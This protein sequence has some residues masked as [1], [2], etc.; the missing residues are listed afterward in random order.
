MVDAAVLEKLE[1]GFAKIAASDS[2]SLLKKYLTK[3]VFDSLKNK[4]TPSFGSTLLDVVQSGFE[5]HDSGVGIY[6]P[7]A[8]AYTTFAELFDPI[9]EDYH[10]G[11][12]KTDKH[13]AKDFG[14]VNAFGDLDPTGE[15]VVST[16]V[17]CGRS[18]EGYPFN[19]CLTEAQYKE[20]EQ[21][22][23][24]TLSGLEGELKGKF[25]PLT[26]MDK[27]TQQQLID[28]H[29]LFK[30]GDRF[31]QAANACRF[32]P[33]GRGI[34]HNDAKTF[35]V[36]CNEED[37]LRIISM[38]MGGNLGEVFRRLTTAVNDIEKRVPF[39]HNDRLGFLT[40][41]PTNLG[42]TIRA[43]VHI[44]VPKLA[45]NKARL[46]EVAAKYNLQVRGTR[47]EHT[48]AEGGIYDISNK[49]R[50]GLTEFQAVKEMY[51]G[52]TEIIK[53]EKSL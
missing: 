8:E 1:A 40:F 42:T 28:D 27:A 6:A 31:L 19:P 46:E 7:D 12:K 39:S 15:F 48:E 35:L 21:K 49:R 50:M 34:Y 2:K 44:K 10:G 20:M 9:I 23:S 41:C 4:K 45:A 33:S 25:Y 30:E 22:V 18:M 51:D 38:Q 53:I 5:N 16:R 11:F 32:W 24:T 37:H 36:W 3:E 14:D 52:I 29:F 43:S 26:G 17:R 47:G 13:P